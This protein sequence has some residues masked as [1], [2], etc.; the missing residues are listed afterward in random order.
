MPTRH[1]YQL[2]R[3]EGKHHLQALIALARRIGDVPWA[4]L[5]DN[6]P[7][8]PAAPGTAALQTSCPRHAVETLHGLAG[9]LVIWHDFYPINEHETDRTQLAEERSQLARADTTRGSV[10]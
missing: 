9:V 8:T 5:R 3:V 1:F 6:R 4:L 10:S 7:F 2:K